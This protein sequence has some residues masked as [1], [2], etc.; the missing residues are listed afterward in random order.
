MGRVW[1]GVGVVAGRFGCGRRTSSVST[2]ESK[3]QIRQFKSVEPI[4]NRSI[5]QSINQGEPMPSLINNCIMRN[6]LRVSCTCKLCCVAGDISRC[7]YLCSIQTDT[8]GTYKSYSFP[9]E[10][11]NNI[12]RRALRAV[13]NSGGRLHPHPTRRGHHP[14]PPSFAMAKKPPKENTIKCGFWVSI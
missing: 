5:N 8:T 3:L 13:W 9:F 4:D 6:M 10:K 2:S 12:Q 7:G 1:S 14:N 11:L